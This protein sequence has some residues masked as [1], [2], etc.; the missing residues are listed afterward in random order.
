MKVSLIFLSL[1]LIFSSCKSSE[2][3][4]NIF[5]DKHPDKLAEKCAGKFPPKTTGFK[6]GEIKTVRDTVFA[7]MSWWFN[8]VAPY[9]SDSIKQRI[10][11]SLKKHPVL[12]K[13]PCPPVEVRTPDT[14]WQEDIA[15]STM[16]QNQIQGLTQDTAKKNQ[17][18]ANQKDTINNY[19]KWK[20]RLIGL[21]ILLVG[22]WVLRLWLKLKKTGTKPLQYAKGLFNFTKKD[23]NSQNS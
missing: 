9:I 12:I 7:D 3:I 21:L 11:D 8:E 19:V 22:I 14:F 2:D 23:N 5:F 15:K 18:I 10:T 1:I 20:W 16:L 17:T 4:A 13:I 6:P